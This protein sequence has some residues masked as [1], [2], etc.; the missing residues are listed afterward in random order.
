MASLSPDPAALARP[1][2]FPALLNVPDTAR[3]PVYDYLQGRN[4]ISGRIRTH[5]K[6]RAEKEIYVLQFLINNSVKVFLKQNT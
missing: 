1:D 5:R 3:E 6:L 4:E 2:C